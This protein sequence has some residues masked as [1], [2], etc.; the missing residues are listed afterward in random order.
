MSK[1]KH[2]DIVLHVGMHKTG[3]TFLQWNV[4]PYV[5]AKFHWHLFYKSEFKNILDLDK[6]PD[7]KKIQNYIQNNFSKNKLNIISEENIY[8]YQFTKEDDRFKRLDRIRK[9]FPEA[10]IIIGTRKA[11]DSIAS[12][13]VEYVAVG[14]TQDFQGF[15]KNFMNLDKLDS[16]PYIE[17]LK[18]YYG[19]ENAFVYTMDELRKDQDKLIENICKFM[20]VKKP[21]KYRKT[22]ARVGYGMTTL[23]ISLFLNRLFK[24]P[25]HPEGIIP[26]WGP[27]LPQNIIFHSKIMK[28]FPKRKVKRKDLENLK[29]DF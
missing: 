7:S 12:W 3:T 5:D 15:L 17:K 20:D 8:T 25:V 2:L 22:P 4:F 11:E 13:Y 1:Q 9:V 19:K 23:K 27:I 24:T 29:I 6:E 18:E 10:K 16:A 26:W 21:I 28:F 14:G